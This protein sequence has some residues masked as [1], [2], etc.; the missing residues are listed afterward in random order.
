MESERQRRICVAL[1]AYAYEIKSD[2]IVDDAKFDKVCEEI[3]LSKTTDNCVMDM[4]FQENFDKSTG[5]WIHKHPNLDKLEIIY[6]K[7]RKDLRS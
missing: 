1:W 3:D 7:L 6:N 5:Q 4:W 2:P